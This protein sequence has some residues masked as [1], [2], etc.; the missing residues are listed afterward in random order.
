MPVR[1]E[2]EAVT[3]PRDVHT[4]LDEIASSLARRRF[5][6]TPEKTVQGLLA[7]ALGTD[8]FWVER[9]VPL[10]S[11]V[12]VVDLLVRR[13]TYRVGLEAKVKGSASAVTRQLHGYAS[14]G[15]LSA[16]VL[17]TTSRRLAASIVVPDG[18][19]AGIPFR[20][21]LLSTFIA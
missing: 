7:L 19:L 20:T 13:G 17:V 18:R 5:P 21:I 15:A 6:P 12:H 10:A 1:P 16:L 2:D 11:T 9:E 3:A 8:D 14:T 4:V